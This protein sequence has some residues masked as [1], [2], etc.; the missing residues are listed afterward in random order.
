MN[1]DYT[2]YTAE[3]LLGDERFVRAELHPTAEGRALWTRLGDESPALA[4]EIDLARQM[5]RRIRRGCADGRSIAPADVEALWRRIGLR[6]RVHD[7]RRLRPVAAIAGIAASVC[8]LL[9]AAWYATVA[10]RDRATDYL[11]I[12]EPF[13]SAAAGESAQ[14][15]LVLSGNR[16]IAIDGEEARVDYDGSGRVSINSGQIVEKEADG[17]ATA[18]NQLSVPRGKR[19]TLVLCDSTRVWINSGTRIVYPATFD[20]HRREIFVDGEI[21]IDVAT[22]ARRPF[23]VRTAAMD[24]RALGTSFDVRAYAD[25]SDMQVVL[26][27]GK[28]EVEMNGSKSILAPCQMFSFDSRTGQ[29]AVAPVDAA[30]HI[31]WKDGYYPFRSQQLSAV[32]RKLSAYYGATFH[33]DAAIDTLTCS[34]KLD[35]KEDLAEVLR[36]LERTAPV[37][38]LKTGENEYRINVKP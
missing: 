4:A 21:Y 32:L 34:G 23:T 20:R 35:L 2:K 24:V 30:D 33:S 25:G 15:Q 18:Y 17:E 1:T 9:A 13:D 19:S 6:N 28:V 12:I 10:Q 8:L 14:V 37:V 27:S 31:A 26:V 36:T 11:A 5:L 22:D 7:R 16:T 3:E 29:T 38:A